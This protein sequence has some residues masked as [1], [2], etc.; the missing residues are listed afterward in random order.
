MPLS[1][2]REH[3]PLYSAGLPERVETLLRR[4]GVPISALTSA[5]WL[6]TSPPAE[7]PNALVLFDSR[8]PASRANALGVRDFGVSTL[9]VAPEC[10]QHAISTSSSGSDNAFIKAIKLQ[11]E[12]R[13]FLWIRLSELPHPFQS[14]GTE[15]VEPIKKSELSSL[16]WS[17]TREELAEWNEFRSRVL[18]RVRSFENTFQIESEV[19]SDAFLPTVDIWRGRHVASLPALPGSHRIEE[20]NLVFQLSQNRHPAGYSPRFTRSKSVHRKANRLA[21]G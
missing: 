2:I 11:V 15:T 6:A 5:E 4:S 8:A 12:S 7:W 13:G 1:P 19:P 3:A 10:S 14:V 18:L 21:A 17:T 9:D 16:Q 20:R